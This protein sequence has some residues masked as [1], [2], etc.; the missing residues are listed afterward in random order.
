[1]SPEQL[2]EIYKK[3]KYS[4]AATGRDPEVNLARQ[5]VQRRICYLR[6]LGWNIPEP[7]C[8]V[9]DCNKR[10]FAKDMCEMH[11]RRNERHGHP[12]ATYKFVKPST[13]WRKDNGKDT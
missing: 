2:I 12:L 4:Y 3:H 6:S 8:Q 1:M 5:A 9:I 11:Y 13:D 10:H 7:T